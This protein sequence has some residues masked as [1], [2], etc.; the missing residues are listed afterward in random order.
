MLENDKKDKKETK[1]AMKET[2]EH[3]LLTFNY[4][5][6][7]IKHKLLGIPDENTEDIEKYKE[8][9]FNDYLLQEHKNII[10]TVNNTSSELKNKIEKKDGTKNTIITVPIIK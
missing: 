3:K 4:N 7:P 5:D 10:K 2:K 8:Y 6:Y 1:K 9:Y